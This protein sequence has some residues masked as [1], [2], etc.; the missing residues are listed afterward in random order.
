MY[1][2]LDI[3]FYLLHVLLM[4]F[5]LSGWIWRS[6][7][8]LHLISL[9]LTLGSWSILGIWYGF[10]YCFLTHWHWNVK[11]LLGETDLP[12]SFV[13]YFLDGLL[14]SDFD[15]GMIDI[16][17]GLGL[18]LPIVLSLYFNFVYQPKSTT[19]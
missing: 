5:N 12:N 11:R 10:G 16:I 19:V 9:S 3:L 7:R 15:A 14:R 18:A 6:T 1:P 13:K 4:G 8:K 2:F 17:T